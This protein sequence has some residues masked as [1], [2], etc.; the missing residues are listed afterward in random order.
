[1]EIGAES[2]TRWRRGKCRNEACLQGRR[3]RK[4]IGIDGELSI[5][6]MKYDP[7]SRQLVI[8]MPSD[9]G[10][11]ASLCEYPHLERLLPCPGF[12]MSKRMGQGVAIVGRRR[13]GPSLP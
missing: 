5:Q 2:G 9:R 11:E 12:V 7:A 1:M 6:Q 10:R 8:F 4:R 3:Q 13:P